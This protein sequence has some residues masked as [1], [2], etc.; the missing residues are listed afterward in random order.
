MVAEVSLLHKKSSPGFYP[1]PDQVS[2]LPTT[3]SLLVRWKQAGNLFSKRAGKWNKK[4]PRS[5][6]S[7]DSA[8]CDNFMHYLVSWEGLLRIP[9]I[10]QN[11]V[12]W[13]PKGFWDN[14]LTLLSLGLLR[15]SF[16]CRAACINYNPTEAGALLLRWMDGWIVGN[17]SI[18]DRWS[19]C[20]T[21]VPVMHFISDSKK[22]R[23]LIATHQHKKCLTTSEYFKY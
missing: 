1:Q 20:L 7:W 19:E 21:S 13:S 22:R 3:P 4:F 11:T 10:S 6:F 8:L 12:D 16:I 14:L 15:V 23:K 9:W 5:Y 17:L 2:P 18:T